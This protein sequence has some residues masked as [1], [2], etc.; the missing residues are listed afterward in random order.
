MLLTPLGTTQVL[1]PF[2]LKVTVTG[3]AR[4]DGAI[5]MTPIER[6]IVSPTDPSAEK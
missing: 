4:E 1:W 3:A 2:V 5:A 6:P